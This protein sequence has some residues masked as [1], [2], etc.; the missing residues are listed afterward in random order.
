M[1]IQEIFKNAYPDTD[2]E[3]IYDFDGC[4]VGTMHRHDNGIIIEVQGFTKFFDEYSIEKY[5]DSETAE[6]L[7]NW[8]NEK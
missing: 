4:E 1:N 7:I 6:Q 2:L 8:I 5:L 3:R